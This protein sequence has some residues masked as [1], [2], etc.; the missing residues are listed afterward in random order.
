MR[1]AFVMGE[2]PGEEVDR[3]AKTALSYATPE[4]EVGIIQAPITPYFHGMSPTETILVAPKVIEGFVEAERRGYDAAVPLGFLDLGVEGGKSAV[5]IPIVPPFQSSLHIASMLGDR[6][7]LISYK[8][9]QFPILEELAR[10]YRMMDRVVGMEESG[11]DLPDILANRD[12]M[13]EQFV[14]AGRKLVR[15]HR[16]EVIIPAGIT[17]CPVHIDPNWLSKELGV[18]VVE[19]IGAPIRF[20]AMLASLGLSQSRARYP[21][22]PTYARK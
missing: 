17:Q 13:V 14:A 8:A 3:R 16:A 2:Y 7:G 22:S 21:L 1:V 12:A 9:E 11:F 18:P 15:E 5:S 4:I 19:G 20:A 6:F 10:R